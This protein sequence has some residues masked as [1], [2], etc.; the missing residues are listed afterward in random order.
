MLRNSA[1]ACVLAVTAASANAE[2]MSY[3]SEAK[4]GLADAENDFQFILGYRYYYLSAIDNDSQPVF[5]Q[6]FLQRASFAEADFAGGPNDETLFSMDAR[7]VCPRVPVGIDLGFGTGDAGPATKQSY[8]QIGSVLWFTDQ[9]DAAAE[10]S[11]AF[12]K[13][14]SVDVTQFQAGAR[15]IP[16][17]AGQPLELALAF[18]SVNPDVGQDESG[19]V[20]EARYFPTKDFYFGVDFDTVDGIDRFAGT[21][22]Y[23]FDWGMSAELEIGTEYDE[24]LL[25]ATA[26]FRF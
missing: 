12:G 6:P 17:I 18:K 20:G 16:E 14:A 11:V 23:C 22:G 24:F 2:I 3:R 7:Y 5:I 19:L 8:F 26:T 15:F 1:L 4:V 21:A 25:R 9:S 10:V 13:R